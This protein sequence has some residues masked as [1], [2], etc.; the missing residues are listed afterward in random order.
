MRI[1]SKCDKCI[2]K[3]TCIDGANFENAQKCEKYAQETMTAKEYLSQVYKLDKQAEIILQKA[4]AMR[5]SLY[6]RGQNYENNGHGRNSG[7]SIAKA[8]EKV[9]GYEHKAD[10]IID[11]LVDKRIEIEN[12]IAAV[13]N[14]IHREVLDRRYLLYQSWDGHY[15]KTNQKYIKG[16]WEEMNFSRSQVFDYH[17]KALKAVD[18]ILKNRI[19]SD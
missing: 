11:Q 1:M 16:I 19:E 18:K 15:D 2:H 7:D 3:K 4:N 17:N 14:F 8:V 5:K 9:V 12:I 13:P 10:E 6:G